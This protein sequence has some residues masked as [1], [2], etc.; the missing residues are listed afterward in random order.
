MTMLEG[1][2]IIILIGVT[3]TALVKLM[4]TYYNYL[5]RSWRKTRT[6]YSVRIVD[7]KTGDISRFV[8]GNRGLITLQGD[9]TVDVYVTNTLGGE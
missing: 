3:M 1:A 6:R 5:H 2:Y 4:P 8:T 9:K 7:L